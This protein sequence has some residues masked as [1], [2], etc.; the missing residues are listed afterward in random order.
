[1]IYI[2]I[3]AHNEERTVGV[4]LWK[5]RSVMA[6][7]RRDYQILVV[8]DASTDRTERVLAP[9]TRILPLTVIRHRTRRGYAASL[10]T[11]LR[12]AAR[13][14]PYP[15]RDAVVTIQADFTED[16]GDI[17]LLIRRIEAG[18]DVV[19]SRARLNGGPVPGGL[20]W[21]RGALG[22]VA[23]RFPWPEGVS[24]PLSGFR[25][26]RVITLRKTLESGGGGRL[27]RQEG[28]G[29]NAELLKLVSPHARRVDETDID[30]RFARRQRESRY[31]PWQ[32]TL[33]LMRALAGRSGAAVATLEY[34]GNAPA[35]TEARQPRRNGGRRRGGRK[36]TPE[37]TAAG[38]RRAGAEG[39]PD[40]KAEQPA[41]AAE[42]DSI[43]QTQAGTGGGEGRR[44]RPGGQRR[45]RRR[46]GRGPKPDAGTA[47]QGEG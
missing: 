37:A 32:A 28:I 45:R 24:D 27:L 25:A 44:R 18:A 30:L 13:R 8:D 19:T 23:R 26:Y 42:A 31:R 40:A 5:V 12:E 47:P 16:P 15:R 4:L 35:E 46:G 21:S 2:C 29:A 17:P 3:P 43:E 10:E 34:D 6:E 39:A 38:S 36:R 20:R 22:Y 33:Q 7:L 41:A 9:Y 1:V 11:L 14:S